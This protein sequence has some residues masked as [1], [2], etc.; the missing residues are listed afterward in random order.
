MERIDKDEMI[1]YE[2]IRITLDEDILYKSNEHRT[3]LLFR[4]KFDAVTEMHK[5]IMK[6]PEDIRNSGW[7][8]L[9]YKVIETRL[10]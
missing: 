6:I 2:I 10:R 5:L 7:C 8:D 9:H 4:N 3:G 1:I